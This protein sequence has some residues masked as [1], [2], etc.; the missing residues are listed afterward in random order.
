MIYVYVG[1]LFGRGWQFPGVR[2]AEVTSRL[3]LDQGTELY[4]SFE[5]WSGCG[6]RKF[7]LWKAS[8]S[9]DP[10]NRYQRMLKG[11]EKGWT[12]AMHPSFDSNQFQRSVRPQLQR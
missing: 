2:V 7:G 4:A 6:S 1:P 12:G 9:V 3:T 10:E 11:D 8:Q 5:S